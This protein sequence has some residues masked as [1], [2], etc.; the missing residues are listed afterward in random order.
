MFLPLTFG[1]GWEDRLFTPPQYT[2]AMKRTRPSLRVLYAAGM[3]LAL[4]GGIGLAHDAAH[5]QAAQPAASNPPA[6]PP[7]N[8]PSNPWTAAQVIQSSELAAMLSDSKVPKA[9]ILQVGFQVLYRSKHIP[10]SIY[11]G[12]ASKPEGLQTLREA[13][14]GLPKNTEIYLYCGC[15]PIYRCPN[16]RPA[17]RTLQA[18]GYTHLH[19]LMLETS[20]GQDWVARGYPIA[21]ESASSR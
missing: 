21:G 10:G 2:D 18:M 15:C 6:N 9:I 14:H 13:V 12:P 3:I 5:A 7:S 8:P 16:I 19:V 11:A 17:F 20:F 1:W 4:V